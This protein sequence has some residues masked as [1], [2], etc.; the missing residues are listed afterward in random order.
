MLKTL[1]ASSVVVMILSVCAVTALIVFGFKDNPETKQFL[2][3]QS[4]LETIRSRIANTESQD[5]TAHPLVIQAHLFAIRI[6]PPS[7]P[8]ISTRIPKNQDDLT[9][10]GGGGSE[11]E[12][13]DKK[14][15]TTPRFNLLAT[16]RYESSPEKSLALFKTGDKQQW[17]RMGETVDCYQIKEIKDGRVLIAQ[18]GRK[19][20]E[21]HVPPKRYLA[22]PL[23]GS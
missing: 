10:I 21:I 14:T 8:A 20:E 18:P 12:I 4:I 5:G 17:F 19:L 16:V 1:R 11:A 6:D 7:P 13:P 22:S 15:E 9:N 2:Q 23:K 3:T